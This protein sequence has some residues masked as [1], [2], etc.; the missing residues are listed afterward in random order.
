MEI[1][2]FTNIYE[3]K[4]NTKGERK[5]IDFLGAN[6]LFLSKLSIS[7]HFGSI[8]ILYKKKRLRGFGGGSELRGHVP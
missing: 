7:V 2:P 8:G 6:F 3:C 5:K 1:I 4:R